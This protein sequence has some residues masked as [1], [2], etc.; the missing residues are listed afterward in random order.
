[1]YELASQRNELES[2]IPW[3]SKIGSLKIIMDREGDFSRFTYK[4]QR[5]EPEFNSYAAEVLRRKGVHL[6]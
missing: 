1:V 2:L 3:G 6:K 4:V 5:G